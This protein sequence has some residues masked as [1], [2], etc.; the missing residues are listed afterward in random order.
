MAYVPDAADMNK[1]RNREYTKSPSSC[2]FQE[3]QAYAIFTSLI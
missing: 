3:E 2:T 1:K